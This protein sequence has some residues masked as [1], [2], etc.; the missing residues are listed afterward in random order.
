MGHRSILY[1]VSLDSGGPLWIGGWRRG[2]WQELECETLSCDGNTGPHTKTLVL[3]KMST[4]SLP[5]NTDT[6]YHLP[7]RSDTLKFYMAVED[8][9]RKFAG[10]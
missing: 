10:P 8:R 1:S 3:L 4:A 9:S 5:I 2:W 7:P 6:P